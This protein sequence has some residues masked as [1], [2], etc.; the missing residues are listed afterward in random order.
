MRQHAR[1]TNEDREA[2]DYVRS[3]HVGDS[4]PIVAHLIA[5]RAPKRNR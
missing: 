5:E 2:Q 3:F 1:V 4:P